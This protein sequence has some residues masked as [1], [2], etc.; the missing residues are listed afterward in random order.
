MR[1]GFRRV[2]A[3]AVAVCVVTALLTGAVSDTIYDKQRQLQGIN[4]RISSTK[5]RLKQLVDEDHQLKQQIAGLDAQLATIAEQIQQETAKLEHLSLQIE[6]TTRDLAVKQ[7]ELKQ[8]LDNYGQRMRLMYKSGQVDGLQLILSAANFSDLLNRVFF[9]GDII[10]DDRR[11]ADQ[12]RLEQVRIEALKAELDGK[13]ADQAQVVKTIQQQQAAL[14]VT[15]NQRAANE[16]HVQ[17]VEAELKQQLDAMQAQRAALQAQLARLRG[18]SLRARSSGRWK[19]PMDGVI[20]QGFGC[21]TVAFEPYDPNCPTRHFHTGVDIATDWGTAVHAAD[22]GIVHN[23]TMGCPWD[24]GQLCGYGRYVI[25]VHAGGFIS[26]Y[27]H[28]SGWAIADGTQVSQDT[29]I[30]YEGS[31]GASTGPHL[32]F[33]I[34]LNGFPVDPMA[35][36][37]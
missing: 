22:G 6:I 19:W 4:G 12:L 10:R 33:E 34:D 7:A 5:T 17:A 8:H 29:V 27:G 26:L 18:E 35:Y 14:Q 1:A 31:T 32:H 2:W 9:F 11:Q 24:L 30:G 16:A 15:R 23:F 20:T 13:R 21:T 37:P 28:L 36:L 25:I 3:P